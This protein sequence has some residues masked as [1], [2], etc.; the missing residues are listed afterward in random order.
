MSFLTGYEKTHEF[1]HTLRIDWRAVR[2]TKYCEYSE[3][4]NELKLGDA[5]RLDNTVPVPGTLFLPVASR[6]QPGQRRFQF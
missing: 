5:S 3:L 4:F 1:S 2:V 6:G